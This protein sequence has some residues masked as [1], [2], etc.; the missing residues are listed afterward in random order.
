M[1]TQLPAK[2][3]LRFSDLSVPRQRLIRLCQ[4]INYGSLRGLLIR[5]R[6]PVFEPTPVLWV[7]LKLDGEPVA[8]PETDLPDFV[9]K[10]E[11]VR[12]MDHLDRL[13]TTTVECLEVRAGTP[14]RVLFI[15][16]LTGRSAFVTF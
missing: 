11:V 6:E 2:R 14:R 15:L 12:L 9:L 1:E 3:A 4:E 7:D 10:E 8:R 13:V 16:S 5:D